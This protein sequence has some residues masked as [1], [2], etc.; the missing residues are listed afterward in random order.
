MRQSPQPSS[1]VLAF[2]SFAGSEKEELLTLFVR[3]RV[4]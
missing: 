3:A 2:V 1:V 4:P